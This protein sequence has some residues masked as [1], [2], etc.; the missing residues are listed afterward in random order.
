MSK[1]QQPLTRRTVLLACSEMKAGALSAGLAALG[2]EILVFPVISM[3]GTADKAPLDAALEALDDYSWIVFTSAYGVR[4]FLQRMDERGIPRVR[5]GRLRVCAVGPATAAA[6]EASGV[7]VSLVPKDYAAEGVLAALA[8]RHG[9]LANLAGARILLPRAKE[10]RDL[11]PRTLEACGARVDVVSCYEN[12]RPDVDQGLVQSVLDH[13]PDA[14]VFTSSSTV[15]NFVSLLGDDRAAALLA[16]AVV[17]ALG[18]VTAE[19]LR[20]AGKRAEI[21]PPENTIPA[22]IAAIL[23]FFQARP[24]K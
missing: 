9:G 14:L 7:A 3:E 10:A 22:L 12:T 8:E 21:V 5:C 19:T 1:V 4:F 15:R 23:H 18:P 16:S 17:A 20:S 6:L 13:P 11:L 24:A 2:A